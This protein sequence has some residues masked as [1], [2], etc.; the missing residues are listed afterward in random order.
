[1]TEGYADSTINAF[2]NQFKN[3]GH[4]WGHSQQLDSTSCCSL[5]TRKL[6]PRWLSTHELGWMATCKTL[7]WIEK[8]SL[9]VIS[10]DHHLGN[11]RGRPCP[12][13]CFKV[14]IQI[15]LVSSDQC[16]KYVGHSSSQESLHRSMKI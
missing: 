10:L 11:G 7:G 9:Q 3:T 5:P 12:L 13:Q 6:F 2:G 4:L 15:T 14:S 1:M 8:G 16:G